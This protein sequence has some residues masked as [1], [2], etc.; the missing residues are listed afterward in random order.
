L[1]KVKNLK[2]SFKFRK[3]IEQSKKLEI[4]I[5]KFRLKKIKKL[6]KFRLK[7]IKKL[8]K[9][10]LKKIK[11][12]QISIKKQKMNRMNTFWDKNETNYLKFGKILNFFILN[13]KCERGRIFIKKRSTG[14]KC[15][16][17]QQKK[18]RPVGGGGVRFEIVF[19]I[20]TRRRINFIE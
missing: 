16:R 19:G 3:A 15:R 2:F 4:S 9:F 17:R 6:Q 10:R 12:F 18:V 7:E 13:R 5:K 8:Q 1:N 11:K 14:R 20:G